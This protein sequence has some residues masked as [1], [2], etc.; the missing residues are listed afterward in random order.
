LRDLISEVW[1]AMRPYEYY[2]PRDIANTLDVS[3][4]EVWRVMDFLIRYRFLVLVSGRNALVKKSSNVPAPQMAMLLLGKLTDPQIGR[5][6][7]QFL[8]KR[9]KDT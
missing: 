7:S 4:A 3:V 8:L 5:N 2:A 1:E 6:P 9:S